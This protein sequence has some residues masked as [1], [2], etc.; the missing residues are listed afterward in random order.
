MSLVWEAEGSSVTSSSLS[1]QI[2]DAKEKGHEFISSG[3][4]ELAV[5]F[6]INYIE[7]L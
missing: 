1:V 7:G 6:L 3:F 2:G 5:S 4:L